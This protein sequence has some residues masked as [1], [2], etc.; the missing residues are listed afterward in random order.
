[1]RSKSLPTYEFTGEH[2]EWH[3]CTGLKIE[4]SNLAIFNT[5]HDYYRT[6]ILQSFINTRKTT[7]TTITNEREEIWYAS[8]VKLMC[9]CR[10]W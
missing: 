5:P 2:T 8:N 9:L 6:V 3:F 7:I 10:R 4:N 1:M